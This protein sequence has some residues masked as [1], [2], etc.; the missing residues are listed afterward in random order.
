MSAP[1]FRPLGF[2]EILDGAFT[3]YRRNFVPF[4]VTA[5]IPSVVMVGGFA[6]L[7]AGLFT[8]PQDPTDPGAAIAV[9]AGIMALSVAAGLISLVLWGALTRESSQAYLG[10][11]VSVSDGMGTALR[12]LVPLLVSGIVMMVMLFVAYFV[13]V[14][15]I[16]LVVAIGMG[17]GNALVA[18]VLGA[19]GGVGAGALMLAMV[20]LMFAAVPAI[21]I[22]DKG[23][24]QAIGRSFDLARGA[25]PRVAGVIVVS[26]IIVYLPAIAVA[27]LTGSFATLSN[28]E[29]VPSMGQ[30]LTQQLLTGA[31]GILTTP[32]LVSVIVLLYFD[33]RVRTEALDVQMMTDRLAGAGI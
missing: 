31:V 26:F 4:L 21:V 19:I 13:A 3:L 12:K 9:F 30:F 16:G 23:P 15:A 20:A 6:F 10:R 2:G 17:A 14:L 28:P 8:T 7:G 18:V 29:A 22:E 11:P 24:I 1:Q 33:R 27:W 25:L 32:F 5:L